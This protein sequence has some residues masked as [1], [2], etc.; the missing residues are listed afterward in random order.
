[1]NEK[2]LEKERMDFLEEV[3]FVWWKKIRWGKKKNRNVCDNNEVSDFNGDF[4][5]CLKCEWLLFY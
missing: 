4:E 3:N 2:Y 5:N 1:M